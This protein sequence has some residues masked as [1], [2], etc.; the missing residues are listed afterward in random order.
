VALRFL[1]LGPFE[2]HRDGEPI[3]LGGRQQRAMLAA[4]TLRANELVSTDRLIDELW[5]EEPPDT[6]EHLIHV[7]V[8]RLRKALGDEG[9]DMLVTRPPGY[10]LQLPSGG[11]D[12]D[13]FEG[14]VAAAKDG[15]GG[16]E[17]RASKLRDA[18]ALWRGP[19][20]S[21]LAWESFARADVTRLNEQ[22]LAVREDLIEFELAAGGT[23]QVPQLKALVGEFPLRE[24]LHGLL[25]IALYREG[26]QGEAL[27][28]F[29]DTRRVLA[30]EL[31][32]DPSLEL[33][34]LHRRVLAQDPTLM[35]TALPAPAVEIEQEPSPEVVPESGARTRRR[36]IVGAVGVAAMLAIASL[37]VW[38]IPSDDGS[39]QAATGG[40]V[41]LDNGTGD[42]AD[43][44][45]LRG[46]PSS[47]AVDGDVVWVADRTARTVGQVDTT[48]HEVRPPVGIPGVPQVVVAGDG[49]A[50]V[51]DPFGGAVYVIDGHQAPRALK[52]MKG[53]VDAVFAFDSLW[54]VEAI[55]EQVFRLDP[56]S[57]SAPPQG[58]PIPLG[59]QSGP[60]RI[61]ASDSSIW[62]LDS[63]SRSLIKIDPTMN[64]VV[65][66]VDLYCPADSP[67]CQPQDLAVAGDTV[68]VA[69][70]EG[71][72]E[73]FSIEG[74]PRATIGDLPGIR[75]LTADEH[76]V[77]VIGAS[78]E[79]RLL[80]LASD[81]SL[82][83][84]VTTSLPPT[85]IADAD[86]SVWVS[87]AAT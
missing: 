10:E 53:P 55:G 20:L 5:P 63:L 24:R 43:R 41:R 6:A 50:W 67:T 77:W 35:A 7:Y 58:R 8:S 27:R 87:L 17:E 37:V 23:D 73:S 16:P 61:A 33:Q 22:R 82:I 40:L 65:T 85:D 54:V 79:A 84:R 29:D 2:V 80:R 70:R 21:D 62:V 44:I 52:H 83:T 30:E 15:S 42:V 60:F 76:G 38:V 49:L 11:S 9:R 32:I 71:T 51:L 45:D 48:T 56:R 78:G 26:R 57:S 69:L 86:G 64:D 28:A 3:P 18:L 75:G 68:W 46:A 74:T 66:E 14:L 12:L 13:M 72:L 81:G 31:G 34:E 19:A 36:W 39:A 25:M 4:L 47:L 1:I 59:D